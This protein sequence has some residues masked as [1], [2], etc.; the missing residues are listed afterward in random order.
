WL[1]PLAGSP[2][3]ALPAALLAAALVALVLGALTLRLSGHYLPLGTIC[4]GLAL[5]ALF[6]T[7][8]ALGAHSGLFLAVI[9]QRQHGAHARSSSWCPAAIERHS[10]M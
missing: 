10:R 4:W 5:Y 2:W 6:G 1:L 9:R 3:L 8:E 7:S